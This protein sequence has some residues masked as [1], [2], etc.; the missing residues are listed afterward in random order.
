[1]YA[2]FYCKL[3]IQKHCCFKVRPV[4][5]QKWGGGGVKQVSFDSHEL[6]ADV[7]LDI[8]KDPALCNY[9]K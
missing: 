2:I 7:F 9:K 8:L 3:M 5:S 1:M 4:S 6:F